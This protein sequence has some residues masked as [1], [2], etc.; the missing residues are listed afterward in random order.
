M[1]VEWNVLWS[2]ARQ[3]AWKEASINLD[4][5]LSRLLIDHQS[6][7]LRCVAMQSAVCLWICKRD[8]ELK[9]ISSKSTIT[10]RAFLFILTLN[11]TLHTS[12]S[13]IMPLFVHISCNLNEMRRM[14]E[15]INRDPFS[16]TG[17]ISHKSFD[18]TLPSGM[19][20]INN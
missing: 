17:T 7:S 8:C 15:I 19:Q 14:Q 4:R 5:N 12:P 2:K 1:A 9:L 10:S 16:H 3:K 18:W 6:S 11:F 13:F 20:V